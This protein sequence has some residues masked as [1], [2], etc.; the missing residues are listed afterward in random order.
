[1]LA[2]VQK[3][4]NQL[5][6]TLIE[7]M[8]G[9][10]IGLIGTLVIMQTFSLFE[11]QKRTTTG[12][13]DAQVNGTIA[14]YNIQRQIQ[15]AGF[16]L[17]IFD[18]NDILNTN[19]LKCASSLID[20]DGDNSTPK[21][22]FFPIRIVDGSTSGSGFDEITVR[23]FSSPNGGLPVN[24]IDTSGSPLLGVENTLGCAQNDIALVVKGTTC[25]A[26]IVNTTNATLATDTTHLTLTGPDVASITTGS[27]VNAARLSCLGDFTELSYVVNGSELEVNGQAVISGIVD[28]QAQYGVSDSANSNIITSWQNA[29]GSWAAPSIADR[30]R[31]RAVR[32]AVLARNDL[33]EKGNV[34]TGVPVTWANPLNGSTAPSF[35]LSGNWQQYRYRAYETIVPI[36]NL[37]WNGESL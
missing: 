32:V 7:I 29:V 26:G 15:M 18:A 34:T 20:H 3:N 4:N 11:G 6:F 22:D 1:M 16:G 10:V 5:G 35:T 37:T 8:V 2:K 12:N 33:L 9:L 36:R 19:P 24:L 27:G 23:Y 13:A 30:N 14:L 17:P 28:L 21:V 25:T 31:I